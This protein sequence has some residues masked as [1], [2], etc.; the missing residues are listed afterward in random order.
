METPIGPVHPSTTT[1]DQDAIS[2]TERE[3]AVLLEGVWVPV[4]TPLLAGQ[5]D[6][7]SLRNLVLHLIAQGVSGLVAMGTTGECPVMSTQEHF[8]VARVVKAAAAGR[9]PVLVGAGGPDTRQV[10][11][12]A[13]ELEALGVDGLLSVC[14]YYNRPSQAGLRAHFEALADAT[15]LPI[16]LYNIPYRTGVN[17][18]N[19]T[20]RA[21]AERSNIVGLKD[22]CGNL[23]QSMQLLANP[24][25]AFSILT[26]EDAL[27]YVMLT[28]GAQ[29]GILAA[30]HHRTSQFIKVYDRV[31]SNDHK[32]ARKL[33]GPL[34][35]AVGLLFSEPNPAPIKA[36]LAARKLIASAEVRLPLLPA[37]AGLQQ[38][39]RA[40][41]E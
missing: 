12:L 4:V 31:R 33:W 40:L 38:Q 1:L 27:F 20:V 28:L 22:S 18:E 5:V 21:L 32:A 39:L 41:D 9:V 23:S 2:V 26:G 30:A 6:A 19:D 16:V 25:H 8:E 11:A 35:R 7:R 17:L 29:G 15:S 37:S 14:P 3:I 10:I 24:P 34:A 13:Q 36:M